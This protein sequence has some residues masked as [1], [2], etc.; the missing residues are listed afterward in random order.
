MICFCLGCSGIGGFAL[1]WKWSSRRWGGGTS[2]EGRA[3]LGRNVALER[4]A[5]TE[6]TRWLTVG[7]TERPVRS[8]Q[9]E[10]ANL[11][12][13]RLVNGICVKFPDRSAWRRKEK[14][15]EYP[16]SGSV[17]GGFLEKWK[18]RGGS[19][20]LSHLLS[21]CSVI[22]GNSLGQP[23]ASKCPDNGSGWTQ[24]SECTKQSERRKIFVDFFLWTKRTAL[25]AWSGYIFVG[26]GCSFLKTFVKCKIIAMCL[27]IF[28]TIIS[29]RL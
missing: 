21:T 27:W 7:G 4:A 3:V 10:H 16:S 28:F 9:A 19:A 29:R 26:R 1:R 22:S 14:E 17:I 24:R 25:G 20:T 8:S 23:G 15:E 13:T 5:R 2:I 18:G 6:G 12:A 11:T